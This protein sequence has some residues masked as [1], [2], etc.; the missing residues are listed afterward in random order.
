MR[1][2]I[3]TLTYIHV[4]GM[5]PGLHNEYSLAMP[6]AGPLPPGGLRSY[7]ALGIRGN[8]QWIWVGTRINPSS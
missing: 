7:N 4:W 6:I 8:M 3:V 5:G 1:A 2:S